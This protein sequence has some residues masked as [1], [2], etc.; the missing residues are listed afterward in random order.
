[1]VS[2]DDV[3]VKARVSKATVSRVLNGKKV[4]SPVAREK[5]L[6]S[7]R[8][9]GYKLNYNIQDLILKRRNGFTRNI[10]FVVV[11][12]DFGDPVYSHWVDG[13]AEAVNEVYYHLLLVKLRGDET[14]VYEL[15]P[16]LRDE[17][18]DG[19][20]LTGDLRKNIIGVVKSLDSKCVVL[21]NYSES[22]LDGMANVRCKTESRIAAM[23][24]QLIREGK[25]RIG[26]V[27][28]SPDNYE[29]RALFTAYR[30][31]LG[32]NGLP[33]DPEICYF[34][35]GPYS[36]IFDI[37][38]PVMKREKLPFDSLIC[39]DIRLA[40]E[41]S[42]LLFGRFGLDKPIDVTLATMRPFEY[43][44]LPVPAVYFDTEVH[45]YTRI[46]LEHLISQIEKNEKSK[47]I[48]AD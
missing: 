6:A 39:S 32:E 41:I 13:I 16:I 35:S 48:S 44:T 14:S 10:A 20:I 25:S 7:C 22:L 43:Y 12:R 21:G 3:A 40:R 18:V 24:E 26:F 46:A 27:A 33:F 37:L 34:G 5:V 1:M 36:G 38:L 19:M 2:M 31:L 29:T 15:P 8:E 23:M 11:G 9:L 47:T 30:E 28:E 4:V 45:D 17:R 42:H